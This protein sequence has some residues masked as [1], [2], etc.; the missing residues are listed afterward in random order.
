MEELKFGEVMFDG[1]L[2]IVFEHLYRLPV[3]GCSG[4]FSSVLVNR[5]WNKLYQH[6][7]KTFMDGKWDK[8]LSR[9]P[10][11]YYC[12]RSL[13][14][15]ITQNNHLMWYQQN[16]N[17][18]QLSFD[19]YSELLSRSYAI[20]K[21]ISAVAEDDIERET[22]VLRQMLFYKFD[23][24]R[25]QCQNTNILKRVNYLPSS[26][27]EYDAKNIVWS[28][29]REFDK[30]I[31]DA[32]FFVTLMSKT[33]YTPQMVLNY[34]ST[35]RQDIKN[36]LLELATQAGC[37]TLHHV[38]TE[39]RTKEKCI[40]AVKLNGMALEHVPT[41]QKTTEVCQ[42]ALNN[43]TEAILF[44]PEEILTE[45]MVTRVIVNDG[46]LY[47]IPQKL[48]T[49]KICKLAVEAN[50]ENLRWVENRTEELCEMAVSKVGR[51]LCC[52]PMKHRTLK[53]CIKAVKQNREALEFVPDNF[54]TL[55]TIS[56]WFAPIGRT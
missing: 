54:K 36:E 21:H 9:Y 26:S 24:G 37:M 5:L 51:V 19:R 22:F 31:F 35:C 15:E 12:T 13:Q 27:T 11:T 46:A 41:P 55:I 14:S 30:D 44:V 43:N 25:V 17:K 50:G 48:R 18:G 29:D 3:I 4:C 20:E 7:I 53:M 32:A 6:P 52:V 39:L 10:P 38:P 16:L 2:V 45:E 28:R 49:D 42:M 40:Q 23:G 1:L 47:S 33:G 56:E 8:N 34:V